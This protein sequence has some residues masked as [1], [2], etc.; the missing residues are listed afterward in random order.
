LCSH[1][2]HLDTATIIWDNSSSVPHLNMRLT[3]TAERD[4]EF[5]ECRNA[6]VARDRVGGFRGRP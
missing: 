1:R 2:V 5:G 3:V 6:L 4:D